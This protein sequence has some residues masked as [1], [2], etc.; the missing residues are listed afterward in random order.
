MKTIEVSGHVGGKKRRMLAACVIL[1]LIVALPPTT[2]DGCGADWATGG[3]DL[4]TR[5][6]DIRESISPSNSSSIQRITS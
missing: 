4:A 3:Q 5:M 2:Y 1:S 6:Q